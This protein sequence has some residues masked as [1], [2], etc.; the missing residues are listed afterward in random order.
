MAPAGKAPE[1]PEERDWHPQTRSWWLDVF[2][3]PMAAEFLAADVHGLFR[4]A[5]LVD[6]YWL[7]DAPTA[8]ARLSQEI[9]LVQQGYGLTPTDRRRLQWQVEQVE[10]RV[11]AKSRPGSLA[12]DDPRLRLAR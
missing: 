1:L 6:D 8:R 7:A 5:V 9:R 3:S 10:Q 4:L 12:K 11:E 2:A